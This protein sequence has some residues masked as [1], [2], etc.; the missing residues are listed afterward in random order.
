[1]IIPAIALLVLVN[2]WTIGTFWI[3]KN[4][5]IA[6]ARRVRESDLLW[7]AVIG[8]SP[9]ALLARQWFRHKAR[10][11]PFSTRLLLIAVAQLGAIIGLTV[12]AL[13]P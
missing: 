7:L 6:G 2:V 1:M 3:D 10:K 8:G 4:R 12:F 9:G 11:E 5:A 13:L